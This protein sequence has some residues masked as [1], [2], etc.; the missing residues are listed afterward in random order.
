MSTLSDSDDSD[1]DFLFQERV[2]AKPKSKKKQVLTPIKTLERIV[3]GESIEPNS[4]KDGGTEEDSAA[5]ARKQKRA[6][7]QRRKRQQQQQQKEPNHKKRKQQAKSEDN[8]KNDPEWVEQQARKTVDEVLRLDVVDDVTDLNDIGWYRFSAKKGKTTEY[9]PAIISQNKAEARMLLKGKPNRN[10]KTKKIQYVGVFWRYALKHEEIAQSKWIPYSKSSESENEKWLQNFVKTISKTSLFKDDPVGLKTEELAVRKMWEKV[11]AQKERRRLEDEKERAEAVLQSAAAAAASKGSAAAVP[12]VSVTQDSDSNSQNGKEE[13]AADCDSDDDD[14][15][16]YD[17]LSPGKKRIKRTSL[18][19]NDEIEF[20]ESI[21]TFGNPSSLQRATVVGIR[22][23]DSSYPLVL[24]NTTMPIPGT[25]RVRRLPDGF[26][27]P[28]HEFV[29][30]Q[31]GTQSL[32]GRGS[33]LH[34]VT[35]RM[36][37]INDDIV[38]ARDDFW[39]N[40]QEPTDASTS[41]ND[42]TSTEA[43]QDEDNLAG[44]EKTKDNSTTSVVNDDDAVP[45]RRSRRSSA[46]IR[47][48]AK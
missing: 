4:A 43:V 14:D 10:F 35:K 13:Q 46:R 9:Y 24:S 32:A 30:L 23:K 11:R 47:N 28:I 44:K 34:Q 27:Q 39:M 42:S 12:P 18:R 21:G 3:S 22:P 31:E 38:K 5:A 48:T 6:Q 15:D 25:H 1:N 2:F 20:Y 8:R 41:E 17:A 45:L 36:R 33:G 29:L 40:G 19:V 16:D 7:A 37:K 26:W